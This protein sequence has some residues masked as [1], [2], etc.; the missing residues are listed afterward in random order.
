M[1]TK[2]NSGFSSSPKVPDKEKSTHENFVS[3]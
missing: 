3:A 1:K 2:Q